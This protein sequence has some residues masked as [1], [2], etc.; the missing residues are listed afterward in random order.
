[1]VRAHQ[2]RLRLTLCTCSLLLLDPACGAALPCLHCRKVLLRNSLL[3]QGRKA[4]DEALVR[5]EITE[6]VPDEFV[7]GGCS[8]QSLLR[9]C[10]TFDWGPPVNAT[11]DALNATLPAAWLH[12]P[13]FANLPCA[14]VVWAASCAAPEP[15]PHPATPCVHRRAGAAG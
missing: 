5:G 1:M 4:Y 15:Q 12:V 6:E 9:A 13:L 3:L 11:C 8:F 10:F 14:P 2:R 7:P